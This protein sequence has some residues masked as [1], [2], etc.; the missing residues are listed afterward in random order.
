MGNCWIE[1]C[2]WDDVNG[3][4]QQPTTSLLYLYLCFFLYLYL[5]LYLSNWKVCL[6]SEELGERRAANHLSEAE[7]PH[8]SLAPLTCSNHSSHLWI[9]IQIQMAAH[10]IA[11]IIYR[12]TGHILNTNLSN[13]VAYRS[14]STYIKA[15]VSK[16]IF[17]KLRGEEQR[18][19]CHRSLSPALLLLSFLL[20]PLWGKFQLWW[21]SGKSLQH[22]TSK[23][24][25]GCHRTV[26]PGDI[27]RYSDFSAPL[28]CKTCRP[29]EREIVTL[30]IPWFANVGITENRNS[31]RN[32]NWFLL[33]GESKKPLELPL[34]WVLRAC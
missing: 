17:R 10:L 28:K 24:V 7:W 1:K 34:P 21:W 4:W 25:A 15:I 22:Q 6:R 16:M 31:M 2:V 32:P 20:W 3:N 14:P 29:A 8:T 18:P 11:Q 27:Q 12:L 5:Y 26:T 19:G 33:E 23:S 9:Q 30:V 13:R